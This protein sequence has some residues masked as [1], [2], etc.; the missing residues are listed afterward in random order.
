MVRLLFIIIYKTVDIISKRNSCKSVLIKYLVSLEKYFSGRI[1]IISPTDIINGFYQELTHQ[2]YIFSEFS[3]K[4]CKDLI[5]KM[6][7]STKNKYDKH[8]LIIFD[9]C[10]R[11]NNIKYSESLHKCDNNL[12]ICKSIVANL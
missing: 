6:T 10:L 3:E 8:I 1:F 12:S 4:W 9:D 7:I 11:D 2:K 5:N